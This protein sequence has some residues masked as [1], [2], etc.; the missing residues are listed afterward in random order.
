MNE[1]KLVVLDNIEDLGNKVNEELKQMNN[2]SEDYIIPITRDRFSNGEGKIKI[3]GTVRDKD[4]YI[5]SD[6]GNYSITYEMHGMKHFMAPDEHF[7]DI[8]RVNPVFL[9]DLHEAR[10]NSENKDFLGSSLIYTSLDNMSDLYLEMLMATESGELCS[11]RFNF[12]GPGP[13]GSINNT[14][15]TELG[16][17]TVTVETYRGYELERRIGDQLDIVE[18]VLEYYGIL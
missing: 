2:E 11:E 4:I 13:I 10:A 3:Q 17:P 15:T 12:Y 7:Q 5:L 16:I 18:Y 6:V 8:K 14:V 1:L 9:F